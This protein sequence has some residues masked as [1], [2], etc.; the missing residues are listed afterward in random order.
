MNL[1]VPKLRRFFWRRIWHWPTEICDEC[2]GRV[3]PHMVSW[4]HTDDALWIEVVEPEYIE[5]GPKRDI[6]GG[7]LCPRCFT[8]AAVDKGIHIFWHARVE[9][10]D[11]QDV[12]EGQRLAGLRGGWQP[13]WNA[14]NPNDPDSAIVLPGE[15]FRRLRSGWRQSPN[16]EDSVARWL[17]SER[18]AHH[19]SSREWRVLDGLLDDYREKA[20]YGLALDEPGGDP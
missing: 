10:R 5:R 11:G 7:T 1:I 14:F 17:V 2:G 3:M 20:D 13:R 8:I 18:D 6:G 19:V 4:W 9:W 16:R 15:D 12:Q